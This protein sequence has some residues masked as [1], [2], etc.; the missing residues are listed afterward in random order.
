MVLSPFVFVF[1]GKY[2]LRASLGTKY[3]ES[4]V[5]LLLAALSSLMLLFLFFDFLFSSSIGYY[6]RRSTLARKNDKYRKFAEIFETIR[7]KFNIGNVELYIMDNVEVNAYAVGSL[8]KNI[9]VLTTGLINTY[10]TEMEDPRD[11]I[12]S[13]GGIMAHELSHLLN[14]DYF[15]A[16][17]FVVNERA[18]NFISWIVLALFEL[19]TRILGIIPVIGYYITITLDFIYRVLDFILVFFYRY[20]MLNLYKF[21]QLQISKSVEYRADEQAAMVI[22]GQSMAKALSPLGSGGYFSIFS[23][24]PLTRHRIRN[25]SDMKKSEFTIRAV[26]GTDLT[27]LLSF[28]LMISI[29]YYSYRLAKIHILLEAYRSMVLFFRNKYIMLRGI[30]TTLMNRYLRR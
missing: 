16:L 26:F 19:I 6:A 20:I 12:T 7:E 4:L 11:F 29:A 24:H 23:S 17:L 18:T 5:L 15:V 28:A 21:I 10:R 3:V 14:R 9:V 1:L 2:F 30:A 22:G 13:L 8:R 25:V 27:F